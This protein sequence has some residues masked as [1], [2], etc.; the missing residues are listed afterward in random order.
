MSSIKRVDWTRAFQGL[1]EPFPHSNPALMQNITQCTAEAECA[2][3]RAKKIK[4]TWLNF[5]TENNECKMKYKDKLMVW[6][7]MLGTNG[8]YES[9][10]KRRAV[11]QSEP[12]SHLQS[13]S[14]VHSTGFSCTASPSSGLSHLQIHG[15]LKQETTVQPWWTTQRKK[16]P[17]WLIDALCS[18]FSSDY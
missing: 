5:L 14:L 7:K 17:P 8:D 3:N 12:T 1:N 4:K 2:D 10:Q 13:K 15:C 16:F 11:V 18:G 6:V 9:K